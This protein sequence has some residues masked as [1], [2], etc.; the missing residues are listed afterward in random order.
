MFPNAAFLNN[1]SKRARRAP[2]VWLLSGTVLATTVLAFPV[3]G[4]GQE[5]RGGL[6]AD[7]TLSQSLSWSDNVELSATGAGDS[8][9]SVTALG[10]TL[11]S[12]TRSSSFELAARSGWQAVLSG[13]G[14][15]KRI[16]PSLTVDYATESRNQAVSLGFAL[17]TTGVG[18]DSLQPVDDNGVSDNEL[19]R[20]T[21]TRT[22]LGGSARWEFGREA[23]FGGAL[24]YSFSQRSYNGVKDAGFFDDRNQ[25]LSANLRFDVTPRVT[26]T[27]GARL[28]HLE[29]DDDQETRRRSASLSLGAGLQISAIDRLSLFVSHD[30]TETER[31]SGDTTTEGL[32]YGA[33]FT[34]ARPR[35]EI[36][37]YASSRSSVAGRRVQL[38]L[39]QKVELKGGELSYDVGMIKIGDQDPRPTANLAYRY[40]MRSGAINLGLAQ[41]PGITS[42]DRATLM[43]QLTGAVTYEV[44]SLSSLAANIGLT[45]RTVLDG[46]DDDQRR[47]QAGLSYRHQLAR[48]WDIRGSY[49]HTRITE[50]GEPQRRSNALSVSLERGFSFRP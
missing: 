35:G 45:E 43:T 16:D 29:R 19:V 6:T 37:V 40:D 33:E 27:T 47:L 7:I 13:P 2:L 18:A 39:R 25:A 10:F 44:N 22:T 5:D 17:T 12:E 49:T 38:G 24:D 14:E 28:T 1:A 15:S 26:L 50:T 34:R 46:Q 23:P 4:I 48:D 32:S 9:R 42:D 36:G 21:G 8:L 41:T 3:A 31:L 30:R 20:R 11:K